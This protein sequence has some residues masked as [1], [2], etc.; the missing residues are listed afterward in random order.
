MFT[1]WWS[2]EEIVSGIESM[3]VQDYANSLGGCFHGMIV[4]SKIH[5]VGTSV[6]AKVHG[7]L[8]MS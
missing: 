7:N 2:L 8:F 1:L 3:S 4:S 5:P 6:S